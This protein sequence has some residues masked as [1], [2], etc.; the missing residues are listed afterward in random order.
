MEK[1]YD[2]SKGRPHPYAKVLK[3]QV[4]PADEWPTIS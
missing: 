4:K 3:N 2:F 1:R